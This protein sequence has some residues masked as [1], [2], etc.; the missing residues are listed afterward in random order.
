M[1]ES[2]SSF[3]RICVLISSSLGD[4]N[5]WMK[6]RCLNWSLDNSFFLKSFPSPVK[7]FYTYN[8]IIIFIFLIILDV[9]NLCEIC[10]KVFSSYICNIIAEGFR[11]VYLAFR[12]SWDE[13]FSAQW[14][15]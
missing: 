12:F 2:Y 7:I 5:L 10:V 11:F 15:G 3:E 9:A 1:Y 4:V 13:N 14:M 6:I 8:K